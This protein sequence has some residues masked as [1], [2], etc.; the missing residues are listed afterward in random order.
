M[1]RI[2]L[3]NPADPADP[4]R[5]QVWPL[6]PASL[7]IC[8]QYPSK[9]VSFGKN[10]RVR[11]NLMVQRFSGLEREPQRVEGLLHHALLLPR[12]RLGPLL[13]HILHTSAGEKTKFQLDKEHSSIKNLHLKKTAI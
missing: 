10:N 6:P 3:A 12:S 8:L 11:R 2:K 7:Y 4:G 5:T 13:L 1:F 9:Q